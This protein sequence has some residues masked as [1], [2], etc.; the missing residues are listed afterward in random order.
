M[1]LLRIP[2][3]FLPASGMSH[4][5][6]VAAVLLLVAACTITAEIEEPVLQ[7]PLLEGLPLAVG[8]YYSPEFRS[9][10]DTYSGREQDPTYEFHVGPPSEALFDQ[11]FAALFETV[12]K[13]EEPPAAQATAHAMAGIFEPKIHAFYGSVVPAMTKDNSTLSARFAAAIV[14]EIILYGQD[15]TMLDSWLVNGNTEIYQWYGF[16]PGRRAGDVAELAMQ[17]AAA[18]FLAGFRDQPP[19]KRWLK[20]LGLGGGNGAGQS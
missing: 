20:G 19:V 17:D 4:G 13:L 11:V 15:G 10:V 16:D 8:T 14:Y 1:K 5:A 3:G 2:A 6:R 9:H 7:Q 18:R 12:T